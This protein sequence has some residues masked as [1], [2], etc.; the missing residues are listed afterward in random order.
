MAVAQRVPF[1]GVWTPVMNEYFA[2]MADAH[3]I[4]GVLPDGAD[5]HPPADNRDKTLEAS[6]ARLARMIGRDVGEA[7]PLEWRALAAFFAEAQLR[8]VH[9]AAMQVAS[10][11]H[12]APDAPLVAAGTGRFVLWRLAE[13]LGR[14]YEE[15]ETS[16]PA[17]PGLGKAIGDVAPAAA[18][19]L[20]LLRDQGSPP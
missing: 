17:A 9:D 16:V 5:L 10:A 19:G 13:R 4:C 7:E 6:C 2:S 20:L 8:A 11:T 14:P 18:V 3:R 15:W 1:R 12:L